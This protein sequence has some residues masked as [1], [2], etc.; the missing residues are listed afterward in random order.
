VND[1]SGAEGAAA[2][3]NAG[4]HS[5]LIAFD[6]SLRSELAGLITANTAAIDG[7]IGAYPYW[8]D[9]QDAEMKRRRCTLAQ[10]PLRF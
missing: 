9:K 3:A 1:F 8:S 10:L 4:G 5:S 6:G 2:L 7:A